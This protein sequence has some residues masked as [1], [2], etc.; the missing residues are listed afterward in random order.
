MEAGSAAVLGQKRK[1]E[2]QAGGSA[3]ERKPRRPR[4]RFLAENIEPIPHE[5]IAGG[6]GPNEPRR[7]EASVQPGPADGSI[8][9]LLGAAV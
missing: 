4:W 2:P 3:Q 9:R 1:A 6:D 7:M 8:V 5:S